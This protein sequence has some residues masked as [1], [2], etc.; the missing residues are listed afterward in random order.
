MKVV[1]LLS[2]GKD[3]VYNLVHCVVQGH[4]PVAVASLGPPEGKDELDSYMYQTVGHSGLR[5]LAQALDLPF[6]VR[7]INGT[8]VNQR[9]EY[10]SRK[11]KAKEVDTTAERGDETE[12]LYELLKSVKDAMPEVQGV[13]VG[14]ILSNYQRVRVEHVCARLGLTP[15]AY[16]WERSQ[17]EL[18]AEMI[19]AGMES[20]LVKVAGAGLQVKHLGQTLAQ[21]QP[22]LHKLNAMYDLHVCGE[23]G[24]YE[25]FTVDCPLFKRRVLLDK[26]T[27][28]VSDS[29]PFSTVAHLHL[30]TVSL[31]P[32]PKP[33]VPEHE[34]FVELRARVQSTVDVGVPP[35][36]DDEARE[37]EEAAR[38]AH[39][40]CCEADDA[41]ESSASAST[42]REPAAETRYDSVPR[43]RRTEDGWLYL[44]EIVAPPTGRN[45]EI[46]Q[47]VQ[48]C[49][50]E[51]EVLL[52]ANEASLLDL[53]HLTVYL[54]PSA[55]T[56]AL[57]PRI[58]AVY[59]TY[60]G[61]SPP[62]RACVAVPGPQEAGA[63]RVKLEGVARVSQ[64][65]AAPDSDSERK[66][67]HIQSMS[68]WAPANIGPYS[69]SI[70]T[71]GKTHIAGQIPLIPASLT[72]P[73]GPVET[74]QSSVA[75]SAFSFHAAL[76]LQHLTRI[77][78]CSSPSE[79]ARPES[80]LAWLAPCP[81]EAIWRRRVAACRAAWTAYTGD[82]SAPFLAVEA[83]A[84]PR[85]AAVE[86]Q[87][88]WT[89][90][91]SAV[92]GDSDDEEESAA[93]KTLVT[94]EPM[95]AIRIFGYRLGEASLPSAA[96][97]ARADAAC[98]KIFY[99]PQ[100]ISSGQVATLF[101]GGNGGDD[102]RNGSHAYPALSFVPA[103]RLATSGS[104]HKQFDVVVVVQHA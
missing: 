2:G 45:A 57:F 40:R 90:P 68:Y 63:Q 34:S 98:V 87:A 4:E 42:S 48:A 7:T 11:G 5:V 1:G 43:A 46:E 47:E 14:A 33:D 93:R 86:W 52:A 24:E 19:A 21:M 88:T 55:E 15:L 66:A 27:T 101:D 89:S 54:S 100:V 64:E 20:V 9:G 44:S 8:A 85:G 71:G 32:D 28:V 73:P 13:S 3:S 62:T 53:A 81:S 83:A 77:V 16:L 59:A 72:L 94:K 60:F 97:E 29:S 103:T 92:D 82:E 80:I 30:D 96:A 70:N 49:F 23:G 37:W 95:K 56:M 61:T 39:D 31:S 65:A 26:T 18:L 76:A 10:G 6:F 69:Q 79:S 50:Q 38:M 67:L 58:N 51:L 75:E 22:T 25:T 41:L 99:R 12:D 74:P 35:L 78:A 84:L 17:P 91:A 102:A 36:L 104:A